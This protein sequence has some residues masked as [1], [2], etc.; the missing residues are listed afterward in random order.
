[1]PKLHLLHLLQKKNWT[2]KNRKIYITTS[3]SSIEAVIMW[4]WLWDFFHVISS[5]VL[6]LLYHQIRRLWKFLLE[7]SHTP[8]T[9]HIYLLHCEHNF[10][11]FRH[12]RWYWM[13]YTRQLDPRGSIWANIW[14]WLSLGQMNWGLIALE[15]PSRIPLNSSM[16]GNHAGG[17]INQWLHNVLYT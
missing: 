1:M 8:S 14:L 3:H 6:P 12:L 11:G 17:G 16:W 13:E 7:T 10:L 9:S 15:A 5:H 2:T 4:E